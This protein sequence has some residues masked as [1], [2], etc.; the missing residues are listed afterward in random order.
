LAR[1]L[2]WEKRLSGGASVLEI[3]NIGAL[4]RPSLST[5]LCVQ[6]AQTAAQV[7]FFSARVDR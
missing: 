5:E 4:F 1:Q 2:L 7:E 6:V 3:A